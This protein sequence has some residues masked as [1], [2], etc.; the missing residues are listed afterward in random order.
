MLRNERPIGEGRI[1]T[2]SESL[3]LEN[4]NILTCL[5]QEIIVHVAS[6]LLIHVLE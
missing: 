2:G 1:G 4:K 5:C 6:L 3:T